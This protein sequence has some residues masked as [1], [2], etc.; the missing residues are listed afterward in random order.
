MNQFDGHFDNLSAAATNSDASLNQLAATTTTQYA[1]RE[2]LLTTLKTASSLSSYVAAAATDSTPSIPQSDS[3]RRIIQ[4][5]AAI[6]NNWH[7]GAFC[8]TH[9]WGVNENH[10][11]KT[12]CAK[13]SSHIPLPHVR[14]L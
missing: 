13:K 9:G 4:L 5:E 2:A 14:T 8:S 7:S 1:E 6:C 3:K 12:C 11:S 10:T